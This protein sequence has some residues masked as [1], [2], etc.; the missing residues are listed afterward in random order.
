MIRTIAVP[1]TVSRMGCAPGSGCC[2]AC[3]GHSLKGTHSNRVFT[4]GDGGRNSALHS[5][6][7]DTVC[8]ADGNCYT[9]G[10]LTAAPLTTG[11]GCP[12]GVAS[13]SSSAGS[14][15]GMSN[16][17]LMYVGGAVLII[18]LLEATSRR[19]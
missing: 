15:L 18:A 14:T 13:C 4:T 1:T 10:V 16:S 17:T 12:P 8:D 2:D 19:R 5:H 7:G 11:A 9:D 6:L 3:G